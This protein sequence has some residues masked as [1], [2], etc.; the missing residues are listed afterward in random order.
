[1]RSFMDTYFVK[2]E[3]TLMILTWLAM[4]SNKVNYGHLLDD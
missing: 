2:M 3:H 4:K 1:M